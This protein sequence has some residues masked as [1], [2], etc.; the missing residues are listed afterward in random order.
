MTPAQQGLVFS[1]LLT[2]RSVSDIPIG[3]SLKKDEEEAARI[4]GNCGQ[5]ELLDFEEFLNSQGLHL[6]I[7]DSLD[8]GVP[9][10]P[11]H[12]N[13]VFVLTRKRGEHLAHYFDSRWY[14]E[15]M[16]DKRR[17]KGVDA[18]AEGITGTKTEIVFWFTRMWLTVQWFFYEKIARHPSQVSRYRDALVLQSLFIEVLSEGIEKM[19][20]SGKPENEAGVMWEIYWKD[21]G[22]IKTWASKFLGVMERAGLIEETAVQGEYQ[23]TLAASVDM[24]LIADHEIEYLMPPTSKNDI[25]HRSVMMITGSSLPIE[26]ETD[27]AHATDQ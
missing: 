15:A 11:G 26:A 3:R 5:R 4:L 1:V 12:A 27:G 24:A 6:H 17:E 23:Q 14:M 10:K 8:L 13:K 19:G 25:T 16:K 21:R 2:F 9:P 18:S 7:L 22:K 20:R